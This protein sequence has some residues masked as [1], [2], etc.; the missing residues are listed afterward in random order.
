MGQTRLS[1]LAFLHANYDANI[2]IE[3]VIDIFARKKEKALKF[4]N[5]C[6]TNK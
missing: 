4:A 3:K 2:D 6:D 1:P 5:I